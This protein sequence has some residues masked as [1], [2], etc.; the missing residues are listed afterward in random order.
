MDVICALEYFAN[1]RKIVEEL[2]SAAYRGRSLDYESDLVWRFS[3]RR[4][5][6]ISS[7]YIRGSLIRQ[8]QLVYDRLRCNG[9]HGQCEN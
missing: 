9:R 2:S 8:R 7:R 4:Q 6:N 5:V 3:R 1:H